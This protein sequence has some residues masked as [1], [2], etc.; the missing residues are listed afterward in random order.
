MGIYI[1]SSIITLLF[2]F[3]CV[4]IYRMFNLIK[5]LEDF[6]IDI[7]DRSER[8]MEKLQE[9]DKTGHFSSDDEIGWTFDHIHKIIKDVHALFKEINEDEL[10]QEQTN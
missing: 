7:R 5:K 4:K 6:V 9:I 10:E 1:Y 2:I 3:S 8:A